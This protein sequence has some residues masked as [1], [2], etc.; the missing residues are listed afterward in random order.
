MKESGLVQLNGDDLKSEA[1]VESWLTKDSGVMI[2]GI[3]VFVIHQQ[4]VTDEGQKYDVVGVDK[5][6]NTVTI[7]LKHNRSPRKIIAQAFEYAADHHQWEQ[8]YATL[9]RRYQKYTGG[10]QSLRQAHADYFDLDN[11]RTEAA[12]N[13]D[14]R[15]VLLLDDSLTGY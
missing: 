5:K 9:E 7:E 10:N 4:G 15:I 14:Q 12:F 6:G 3:D 8:P 13:S 2:G 11:P 1:A